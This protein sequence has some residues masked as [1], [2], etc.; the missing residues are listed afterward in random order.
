MLE[1]LERPQQALER[2]PKALKPGGIIVLSSPTLWTLKGL[3]TRLTPYC[4]HLWFYRNIRGWKEA[5][6]EGNPPFPTFLKS[7]STP[8][9]IRRFAKQNGLSVAYERIVG[10]GDSRDIL[11]RKSWRVD[12]ALIP[13]N[14]LLFL[15]SLGKINPRKVQYFM[16]LLKPSQ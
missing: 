7:Q 2:F 11:G 6:T 15:V 10:Y 16:M 8:E 9:A 13:A 3:I 5:G 4:F 14:L 1:H 12:L